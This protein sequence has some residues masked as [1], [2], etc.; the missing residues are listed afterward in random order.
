MELVADLG[1][2][3][4]EIAPGLRYEPRV[5]GSVFRPFGKELKRSP[6]GY[7]APPDREWMLLQ[8]EIFA[9][10]QGP[11][12]EAAGTPGLVDHCLERY[13]ALWPLN[14]WLLEALAPG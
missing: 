9:M 5:N 6:K 13:T 2:R 10:Q 12:P 7:S 4:E 14:R 1:P 3:L 8:T 11:V